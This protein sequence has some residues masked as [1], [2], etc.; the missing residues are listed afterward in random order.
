M[1]PPTPLSAETTPAKPPIRKSS[2]T[3]SNKVLLAIASALKS[4]LYLLRVPSRATLLCAS[5]AV[6]AT[7]KTRAWLAIWRW[8]D[9][10]R[11]CQVAWRQH[12]RFATALGAALGLV[13]RGKRGRCATC[14]AADVAKC[15]SNELF[16]TENERPKMARHTVQWDLCTRRSNARDA[17]RRDQTE[18]AAYSQSLKIVSIYSR[19]CSCRV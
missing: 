6:L 12:Q 4:P 10:H 18:D 15:L 17:T 5:P 3:R 1:P 2:D 9:S 14:A 8:V 13:A 7:S 16:A 11:R 19:L